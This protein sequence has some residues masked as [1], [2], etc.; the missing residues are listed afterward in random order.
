MANNTDKSVNLTS[1][2]YGINS[3]VENVKKKFTPD[4]GE[5]TLVL[6]TFGYLGQM[7]SDIIQNTIVMASEFSNESIPTKAKFEK[8]IIAHALGLG[9]DSILATPAQF[10]VLLTFVEDDIEAWAKANP[11]ASNYKNGG[12][13]FTFDR[14]IPIYIGDF[15]FHTDYDILIRKTEVKVS[16]KE[17]TYA[18]T[19]KYLIDGNNPNPVSDIE[20][21]YLTSPVTMV[22]NEQK[23]IFTSCTLRQVEKNTVYKKILADNSISSKTITFEFEG[24]LA[25][26]DIDV[27]EGGV[28]T[29]LVPIYE[30]LTSDDESIKH[31]YYS[32]LD[33]NVI[34]IKFDRNSYQPRINSE[35]SINIQTTQGDSGNFVY[36]PDAWPT[37]AFESDKY[38]YNN[39]GCSIRPITGESDSGT[40]KKSIE[41][42]KKFIPK[43]ALSRGSITNLTDLENY[44]NMI[45]TEDSRLYFYKKRDNALERLYYSFILMRD[46]L[47]NVI[48]MN[49][50]DIKLLK[51]RGI[52]VG[53]YNS[54]E[55]I[56]A[57]NIDIG[58]YALVGDDYYIYDGTDW[59]ITTE[60]NAPNNSDLTLGDDGSKYIFKKGTIVHLNKDT[61]GDEPVY[62]ASVVPE[63]PAEIDDKRD[64][65]YTIPYNFVINNS[66][67]YGMYSLTT[68][69]IKKF[70]DFTY[71]NESCLFQYIA[72]NIHWNRGYSINQN[73][74]E[75]SLS[76]EQNTASEDG[77]NVVKFDDNGNVSHSLIRCIAVLYDAEGNPLRWTEARNVTK[78]DDVKAN[79]FSFKFYFATDDKIDV[80]N[81]IE[82]SKSINAADIGLPE[83]DFAGIEAGSEYK[84]NVNQFNLYDI[85]T[86]E[87]QLAYFTPNTK[88][89][90]H[91]L[92]SQGANVEVDSEDTSNTI[93]NK[94]NNL[95][96]LI[97]NLDGYIL[98]NSYTVKSGIDFFYDY[99]EITNSVV[100][101]S[102]EGDNEYFYIQGVPVV[103]YDY[104]DKADDD[105]AIAFSNEL[106][107]RKVYI[108]N[109]ID[110][111][112]DAF[113]VNFKFF[114]TYGP[115]KMFTI[116]ETSEETVD[117]INVSLKF[118]LRLTS[119]YDTN[120]TNN[121]TE[122][123]KA[124]IE[125]LESI[126]SLHIPNLVSEI[127]RKYAASIIYF[128]FI[129]I[130]DYGPGTQHLLSQDMPAELEV[131][132]FV[133]IHTLKDGKPDITITL[134]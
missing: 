60:E 36:K 98:T 66:P 125:D 87:A 85:G 29:H 38:G 26:F 69:D 57:D 17:N 117:R 68:I 8:N 11:E 111:L 95:D 49:T 113:G 79:V 51:P 32:Y 33:S 52:V 14:N 18:Y 82:I 44:F 64:F 88:C 9:I 46:A 108:D 6:G 83:V 56:P 30:G 86:E 73:I 1:D 93:V 40:D 10:N 123:I 89:V 102:K 5:E 58:D 47:N 129:G 106:I 7:F 134:V 71:I 4:V 81:R 35:V 48:P 74:Y 77:V 99:S 92:T 91:I 19:A 34:R 94:Y 27:I 119:N 118:R 90:I 107:R 103:K 39:I 126:V 37:Y 76:I 121:I 109:T 55:D 132:E 110:I 84:E 23:V 70:L 130:N 61:S 63:V 100:T 112:E 21:P 50:I 122:D 62:Y 124:Y 54:V 120:I 28:T 131:P 42:L 3:Y 75:M 22:V 59:S 72:T 105:K 25:A 97:P 15:E 128:E 114:N 13:D 116:S 104:F 96:K 133:N 67:L 24:Q 43:E 115:S 65:Y 31:F 45:N 41:E 101:V 53:E 2:V 12:W 127:N 80:E 78:I 20:N 16:G